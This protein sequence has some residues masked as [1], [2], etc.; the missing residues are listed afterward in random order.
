MSVPA[1]AFPALVLNAD[2]RPLS[3]FPLSV[4]PW[5]E[6]VKAVFL[7]RVNIVSEYD[8]TVHSPTFEMR[9]PSVISLKEYVPLNRRPAF[10][11]F[12]VFLRDGFRCQYSGVRLPA[13]ELTFDHVIPRSRGGRTNWANVVTASARMNL[14]KA[15]RTPEEAGMHLL[16]RPRQPMVY[17]LQRQARKFPPNYLHESWNDF[18]YWDT[19][20]ED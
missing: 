14:L 13:E 1:N 11:R 3:Y 8:E 16:R 18:L 12:N 2:F 15:N 5:Q 6:T 20:L 19:E 4:W 9:L 17:E 10:T 7:E